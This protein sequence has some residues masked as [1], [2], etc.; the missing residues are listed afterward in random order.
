MPKGICNLNKPILEIM[1]IVASEYGMEIADLTSKCREEQLVWPRHLAMYLCSHA[2]YTNKH[3]GKTFKRSTS[4]ASH[5]IK[6]VNQLCSVYKNLEIERIR[7]AK[8]IGLI[9]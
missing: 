4:M 5:A 9:E 2:G 7:M 8:E 6:S 3:I 1:D